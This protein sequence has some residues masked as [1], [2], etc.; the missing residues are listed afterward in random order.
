MVFSSLLFVFAFLVI[1][2]ILYALMPNM[3]S[4]NLILLVFSLIFYAWGGPA[5]VLLLLLMT[6]VCYLGGRLIDR[7]WEKRKLWL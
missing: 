2:Y 5:L 7:Y 4:R 1:C 3:K 6:F